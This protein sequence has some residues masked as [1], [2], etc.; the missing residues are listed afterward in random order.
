MV[1]GAIFAL[2]V[3]RPWRRRA[4]RGNDRPFG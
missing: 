1:I 3:R 4:G 2:L